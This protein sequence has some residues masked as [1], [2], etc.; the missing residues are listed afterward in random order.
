M[1]A[2]TNNKPCVRIG[3]HQYCNVSNTGRSVKDYEGYV[4]V[5]LYDDR[6]N[7]QGEWHKDRYGMRR[8][9]YTK[10]EWNFK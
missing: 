7:G 9:L 10:K 6:C 4:A 8:C 1:T 3:D 5:F 2:K